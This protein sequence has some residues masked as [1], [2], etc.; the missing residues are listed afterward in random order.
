MDPETLSG[1]K[2]IIIERKRP[3]TLQT[4]EPSN[5]E[6]SHGLQDLHEGAGRLLPSRLNRKQREGER[7]KVKEKQN[8]SKNNGEGNEGMRDEEMKG[9][10]EGVLSEAVSH[11]MC[12]QT[13]ESKKVRESNVNHARRK[14][15][16]RKQ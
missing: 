13:S 1:P 11:G 5:P 15:I 4:P 14:D 12:F 8:G 9:K 16:S 2:A 7:R 10:T 6:E 3:P